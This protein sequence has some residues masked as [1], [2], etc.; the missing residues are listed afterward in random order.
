MLISKPST[1]DP[2]GT[3]VFGPVARELRELKFSKIISLGAGGA[4]MHVKAKDEVV[5]LKGKDQGKRGAVLSVDRAAAR[6]LVEGL[7]MVKKHSRADPRKGVQGGIVER[8][9]SIHVSNLMVVCPACGE[10]TRVGHRRE[11]GGRKARTCKRA[12]C[13]QPIDR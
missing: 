6:A 11:D 10:P 4:L 13:G 2:L 1:K 7:N 12:A 8:E 3:R 5:L 9:A